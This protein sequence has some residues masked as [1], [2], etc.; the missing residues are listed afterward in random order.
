MSND[1]TA[2]AAKAKATARA[3]FID[4]S[5]SQVTSRGRSKVTDVSVASQVTDRG[6]ATDVN[7]ND[8][9]RFHAECT[10]RL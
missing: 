2:A 10:R 4:N 6:V 5:G 7:Q 3:Q 8:L 1:V 9:D